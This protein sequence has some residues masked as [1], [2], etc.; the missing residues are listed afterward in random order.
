MYWNPYTLPIHISSLV[1][2]ILFLLLFRLRK[3]KGALLFAWVIGCFFVYSVGYGLVISSNSIDL[4]S[5]FFFIERIGASLIPSF[6]LI[7]ALSF[8]DR[9]DF[10]K[11]QFIPIYFIIPVLSIIALIFNSKLGFFY[12]NPRLEQ[13]AFFIAFNYHPEIWYYIQQFYIIIGSLIVNIILITLFISGTG[14]Y[15]KQIGTIVF[16]SM[17]MIIL[18]SLLHPNMLNIFN[19]KINPTPYFSSISGII[20]YIG[21]V[22]YSLFRFVPFIRDALFEKLADGVIVLDKEQYLVDLNHNATIYLNINKNDIGKKAEKALAFWNVLDCGSSFLNIRKDYEYKTLMYGFDAFFQINISPYYDK[23]ET[24]QGQIIVMRDITLQKEA[25]KV[26][27]SQTRLINAMLDNLPIGIFMVEASTGKP[28]IANNR[29]KELLGRGILPDTTSENLSEVYQAFISGTN[30]KYPSDEMPIVK[31]MKGIS[32]HVDNM[33][34]ERPDGSRIQL[35]VFGCPVVDPNGNVKASLVGFFDIS[36]RIKAEEKIH[37]QNLELKELNATKDK[38]FSIIAHDLKSPFNAVLG[39]C[40]LLLNHIDEFDHDEIKEQSA[41][42]FKSANQACKLTENLLEW[43]RIQRGSIDYQPQKEELLSLID[44]SIESLL[45]AARGKE[46]E[47]VKPVGNGEQI[48]ADKRMATS[49]LRNLVSNAIKFSPRGGNILIDYNVNPFGY[50]E[51]NITDN[52][53]GMDSEMA[54][55][56]FRIDAKVNRPGTEGESSSGLGLLLCKEFVEKHNGKI[57][58]KSEVGKGSTFT[59]TVPKI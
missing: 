35:E 17:T 27:E 50:V 14:L 6:Y 39:Y 42:I 43:A 3:T 23:N 37:H 20:I 48:L 41:M 57:W 32:S 15:R 53:I 28:L 47:I 12:T 36:D 31:G 16:G 44:E 38:F 45:E 49:I 21:L 30:D 1:L 26:M 8:V 25:E 59:F 11:K 33:E 52:G 22:R 2:L 58:V 13:G 56:I 4:A 10:L 9:F 18:H 7:F 54:S 29:A 51:I 55:N 19:L 34:V 24:F 46:I 5:K 40:N